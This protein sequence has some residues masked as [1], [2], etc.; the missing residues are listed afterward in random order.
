MPAVL[1]VEDDRANREAFKR[2]LKRA[3]FDVSTVEN[4]LDA[5]D[6]LSR[7]RFDVI[8]CDISMPLLSGIGFFEQLEDVAPGM[9]GRI[10]FVTAYADDPRVREFIDKTGQPVLEK[11]VE[12]AALVEAVQRVV[13]QKEKEEA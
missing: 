13:A 11:P 1:I 7:E 4:G 8:V 2:I 9:G 6:V 10:L 5:L 12:L 3:G